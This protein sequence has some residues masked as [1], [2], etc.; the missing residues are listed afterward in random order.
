MK[1][2]WHTVT[3]TD[4]NL[5]AILNS[6]SEAYFFTRNRGHAEGATIAPCAVNPEAMSDLLEALQDCVESMSSLLSAL[7]IQAKDN[8]TWIAARAAITKAT[9]V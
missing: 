3:N 7:G 4:G 1:N 5:I 8:D 9:Q 6:K 2:D